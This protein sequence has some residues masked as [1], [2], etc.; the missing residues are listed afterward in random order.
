MRTRDLRRS[1]GELHRPQSLPTR[2]Q[3]R[4][5]ALEMRLYVA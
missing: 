1:M 4:A 2:D 3:Q 5:A